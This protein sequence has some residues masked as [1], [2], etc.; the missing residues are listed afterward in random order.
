M[1][2]EETIAVLAVLRA[3]YPSFYRD[4]SKQSLE[5]IVSLWHSMFSAQPANVV[6]AAVKSLIATRTVGYPP[7]IGEI[8]KEIQ[9]L[10][11]PEPMSETEA[12]SLV[13]KACRNGLYGAEREFAKLPPVIQSV[14][15]TPDTL[16]RWAQMN[17]D[18]LESV[19]ASNFMRSFRQKSA[20]E[21]E[22]EMLPPDIREAL[23]PKIASTLTP[24]CQKLSLGGNTE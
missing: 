12:W 11:T 6:M 9:K 17:T 10:M 23:P 19:V 5:D 16:R 24:L 4:Y 22:L 8:N 13:S 15:R 18:E 3:A 14:L 21:T 20:R 7:V 2:R 1:T